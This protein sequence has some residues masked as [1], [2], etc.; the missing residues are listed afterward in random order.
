MSNKS[1]K[2]KRQKKNKSINQTNYRI[3]NAVFPQGLGYYSSGL[4]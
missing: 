3:F 2:Y 4:K 1:E